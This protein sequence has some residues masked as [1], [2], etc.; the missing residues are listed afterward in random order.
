MADRLKGLG[1]R[2]VALGGANKAYQRTTVFWSY[3]E[4]RPAA[5]ALAAKMGWQV[6]PKPTNLSTTVALHIIVGEDE[7]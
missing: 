1:F 5:K 7:I 4:A 6:G 2:V 3:A